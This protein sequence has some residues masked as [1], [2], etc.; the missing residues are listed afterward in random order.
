LNMR[1]P[2]TNNRA[3]SDTRAHWLRIA[4]WPGAPMVR[5]SYTT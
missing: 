5:P 3:G 2:V 1:L 4:P